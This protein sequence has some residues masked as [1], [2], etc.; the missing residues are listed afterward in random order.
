MSAR[1]PCTGFFRLI[2]ASAATTA[3]T[4]NI[5]KTNFSM[6]PAL[7]RLYPPIGLLFFKIRHY[8]RHAFYLIPAEPR[9]H[10]NASLE[11]LRGALRHEQIF[12]R[13][14]GANFSG[15]GKLA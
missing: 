6:Y 9:L 11:I 1:A 7:L 10:D 8:D 3:V 14:K 4:A 15:A 13:D 2:T 12:L 5:I